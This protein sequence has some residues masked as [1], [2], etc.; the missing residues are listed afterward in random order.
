MFIKKCTLG[1]DAEVKY[2]A[3]GDPVASISL[4]YNYGRKGDD[5]K[6]PTQWVEVSLWG[7]RAETT[8]Q[9]LLKGSQI[10]AVV[11]EL[12]VET[13]P[14]K[15]GTEGHKLVGILDDFEFCGSKPESQEPRA[16]RQPAP[17]A[18]AFDRFPDDVPF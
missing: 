17:K 10:V 11:K 1:R 6:L 4:A 18:C 5:G 13:Y 14:K 16:E 8:A 7:K 9:Y 2:T 12:H 3:K 15:D